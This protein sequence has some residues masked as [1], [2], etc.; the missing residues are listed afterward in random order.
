VLRI[1]Q[2]IAALTVALCLAGCNQGSSDSRVP[3]V[4]IE[5]LPFDASVFDI[6]AD[7]FNND[8]LADLALT[9]H[10][11]SFTQLFYQRNPRH[12]VPGPTVPDVGFHPGDLLR[13]R[14]GGLAEPLY[15]MNAEG[16]NALRIFGAS[17]DLG[18]KQIAELGAPAPRVATEF[19]WPDR[20]RGLAFGPFARNTI[21]IITDF[22]PLQGGRG[23]A[24]ELPLTSSLSRVHQIAAADL[25]EDGSDEIL[26][27]DATQSSLHAVSAPVGGEFPTIETLW[28]F[29]EGGRHRLVVPADID[30]DG[31]AELLVPEEVAPSN[32]ERSPRVFIFG[33]KDQDQAVPHSIPLQRSDD[34]LRGDHGASTRGFNAID[35]GI[36][37]NGEG[38][39]L[40][41]SENEAILARVPGGWDGGA[42]VTRSVDFGARAGVRKALLRDLDGDGWLDAVIGLMTARGSN[43]IIYGPLWEAAGILLDSGKSLEQL[44]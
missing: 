4:D 39:L 24:Y 41:T 7:D 15:L 1:S 17:D 5:R 2:Q 28:R 16:E 35:F 27:V 33:L 37:S 8:G 31:R 12:F 13:L 36:D 6:L 14:P 38:L 34:D 20:G 18:L 21:F 42:L 44:P 11:G 40:L 26:F 29:D 23:P 30:Q 3:Q 22:E 19:S 10:T 25:D 9:T 32:R 43:L